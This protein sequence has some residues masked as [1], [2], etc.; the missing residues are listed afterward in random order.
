MKSSIA[1]KLVI[2]LAVT[3]ALT[4]PVTFAQAV[5]GSIN[6]VIKDPNGAVVPGAKVVARN[7]GTN[8]TTAVATDTAGTY[9]IINLVPGEYILEVEAKGF[10]K[11]TTIPQRLSTGDV[12]RLD[13]TLEL[14]QVTETVTVEEVATKVNTEDSQM[15]QVLRDVYQLPIISAAAGR[16]P[17]ALAST[18]PGVVMAPGGTASLSSE[19]YGPMAVNGQRAQSNNYMLDGGDSNDLAIN[20]PDAV[21]QISPNAISEFRVVTGSMKAEYGRNSG[22]VVQVTTRSG[23]NEWHGGANEV[24]RNTKLNAVPFFQKVTPGPVETFTTGLARKPQWNTNDFDA[25]FGGPIKKDKTF[26]FVNYLGFR[27]RQGVTSS[28]TVPNDSQRALVNQYG[29][30]AA[31]KLLALVPAASTGNVLYSSPTNQYRRDQGLAKFDHYFTDANRFSATYFVEQQDSVAPF[32]GFGST[33]PGFGDT[34]KTR[35]QNLIVRDTHTFGAN[36]FNEF[37][38][39]FHRRGQASIIPQNT[40]KLSALGLT[41]INADD[42]GAEGPPWVSISGFSAF[43]NSY[44]GPQARYDNTFQYMDSL[45][46]TKGKHYLKFGGEIRTFAQNQAFTF[47]NNGYMAITGSG[48]AL[49]LTD[50]IPGLTRALSDFTQG[51]ATLY[52]QN[53]ANRQGYRTRAASLFAQDDWKVAPN[54]TLNFGLRWE[55]NTGLKEL[56]DQALAF[57]PT[58]QSTVFPTAPMGMVYPGDT[59]IPRSTYSEDLRDFAPRVGFAWDLTGNGKLS[60]RGGYG[61]F[62]DAPMSELTLQFL[63]VQP[64]GLQPNL[65]YVTDYANPYPSSVYNPM[66]NPFPFKPSKPG[67]KVDYTAFGTMALTVM[68]PNFKTPYGQQAN[69]QLQ[70]QIAK[71]WLIE[72]GYV[73]SNGVRLLNRRE[74][75]PAV[76]GPGASDGD[77]DYR[78]IYNVNHP[79]AEEWGGAVFGGITNQSS[80]ANSNYNS[81]QVMLTKR[82]G[83]GLSMTNAYTWAH[84]IDN[85][86]GLR[87]NMRYN[88]NTADRGNSDTDV[89][90]RYVLT[91]QYE[92]PFMKDQ[93]GVL[94]KVLGGW[95]VSGITTFQTGQPFSVTESDDR[96]LTGGGGDRPDWAG[97]SKIVYYDPRSVNAVSGRANSWFDGTGGNTDDAA[98]SPYFRRVGS[99]ATWEDGA[100]RFGN[101]GRN[102]FFA[103]GLNNWDFSIGKRFSLSERHKLDFR[104]E[105]FNIFNHTQFG[106]PSS[107][108]SSA[109]FGRITSARDPRLVQLSL[110]Y[111]F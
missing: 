103:P 15:G 16:N 80:D 105:L 60:L 32:A 78:R 4:V 94:G 46:W 62:Y 27:R 81:L 57:R 106:F 2:A 95:N 100:G 83:H 21:Q 56:R 35:F 39:S 10:R 12:L 67:D 30:T 52:A 68:D 63:G 24:F 14:G 64:Y 88:S 91:Y 86:S 65:Y 93:K 111:W 96:S 36:V 75:N 59:G 87:T 11:T 85:A 18:Q 17:L 50:A 29:T 48:V 55:Y 9:K 1:F 13:L 25:Q 110:K 61:I 107:V 109:T 74:I 82:F 84:G 22:A 20:V 7:A 98:T 23:T 28:A 89:R 26:F 92:L 66:A 58:Q 104:A 3:L 51:F 38:G 73:W 54:F 6:G 97:S 40:T 31:K 108:I 8:A 90:H 41:G 42:P 45:S 101:L 53:N 33:V 79:R 102:T 44:Q 71:D 5:T 69:L 70:Y 76:P 47:I 34:G 72:T 37:R 19:A 43:G 77:T 99:A 49:G